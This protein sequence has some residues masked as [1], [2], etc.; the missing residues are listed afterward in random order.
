MNPM[1]V[2]YTHDMEMRLHLSLRR[3][4][5]QEPRQHNPDVPSL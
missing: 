1:G 4:A 5:R 3:G 2:P